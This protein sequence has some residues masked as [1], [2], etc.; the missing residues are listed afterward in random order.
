ML[1]A[2]WI[3]WIRSESFNKAIQ[4]AE[5]KDDINESEEEHWFRPR[6]LESLEGKNLKNNFI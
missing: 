5:I 4:E 1:Q 2:L 6:R 3:T